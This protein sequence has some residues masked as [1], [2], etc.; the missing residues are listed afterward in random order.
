VYPPNPSGPGSDI[1]KL[2]LAGPT[3]QLKFKS[4]WPSLP[5]GHR[6]REEDKP[7]I[8]SLHETDPMSGNPATATPAASLADVPAPAPVPAAAGER[9]LSVSQAM[10]NVMAKGKVRYVR[11]YSTVHTRR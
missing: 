5:A 8:I 1:F 7:C 10:S 4:R 2:A 6:L 9:G 11:T 3:D